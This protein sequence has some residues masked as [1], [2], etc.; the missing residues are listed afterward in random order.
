MAQNILKRKV[1]LFSSL[2]FLTLLQLQVNAV[3]ADFGSPEAITDVDEDEFSIGGDIF[4]DFN[5]DL[6]SAQV[7]EDE[8]FYRYGRFYSLNLGA[9][10][11]TFTGN[12]GA[13]YEDRHPTLGLSLNYFL[14]FRT[15]FVLGFAYSKHYLVINDP[16][17][18]FRN[19][20]PG[21]IEVNMFRTFF[22][23]RYY[24]DTFDLGT[25]I[26]YSNPYIIGRME[27]WNQTNKF[28]DSPNIPN[29]S[30]GAIG[31]AFGLGFEFPMELKQSYINV[32]ILY[33][34]VN[35]N[36]TYTQLYRPIEGSSGGYED[37]RG[38]VFSTMI[39]YTMSW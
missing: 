38:A 1:S 28:V 14:N 20:G 27:F 18:G 10:M 8:R 30:N 7:M 26:T 24:L 11:T 35:F 22:G 9:G 16:V 29:D 34:T 25:A 17:L 2:L 19:R 32:E 6:E 3:Y 23:M 33:H 21:L 37:L 15:A 39:S 4:S 13:A 36:D 31:A 5:E 12:R